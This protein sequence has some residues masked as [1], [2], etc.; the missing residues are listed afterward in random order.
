M[1][2]FLVVLLVLLG[3]CAR[4]GDALSVNATGRL[5]DERMACF[6]PCQANPLHDPSD[7]DS[8]EPL[9]LL[10]CLGWSNGTALSGDRTEL[11][12]MGKPIYPSVLYVNEQGDWDSMWVR[13]KP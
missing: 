2:L 9:Y 1:K 6:A 10:P 13:G 7:L 4:G 11:L 3:G 5:Y 8:K 12:K